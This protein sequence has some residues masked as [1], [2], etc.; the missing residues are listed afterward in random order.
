MKDKINQFIRR[1]TKTYQRRSIQF[2][3]SISFT[4][5]AIISMGFVGL[6]LYEKYTENSIELVNQKNKQ[7]I[8]QAGLNLDTYIRNMMNISDTMY[9]S[10]IKGKDLGYED[11][12]KEMALLYEANKNNLISIAC[13]DNMG[14]LI[15]ASP[16]GTM[17]EKVSVYN[18]DWFVQA[19]RKIENL[20]FSTPHV[21]DLFDD[22][23]FRYYW[24]VSL[25]RVVSLNYYGNTS[26]GILLVDMNFSDI[27]QLFSKVNAKGEGYVYLT[28]GEGEIIYHPKQK[29][30]YTNLMSE[31]NYMAAK[32][33]D[34][35]HIEKYEGEER[36]VIVKTVG[37]T[38]WKI[39]SVTPI[40]E[41]STNLNQFKF[42]TFSI[43]GVSIIVIIIG[44][45][46]IS[47]KVT[48]PIRKLEESVRELEN[49][50]LNSNIYTEGPHEIQHL[51]ST[52]TSMVNQMKNMMDD[53]VKEQEAKKKSE[54]DAL[55]SQINPHFL[56]NTLDS[57]VWMVES[58]R[59]PEAISMVTALASLFRISLSKGK[60]IISIKDE[61]QHADN[62]LKIQKVRYKD[63]FSVKT[64]IDP[65]IEEYSTIK[66]IV[67]PLLENAIYYG[68]ESMR[69]EGEITI[70]GYEEQGDIFIEVSDNGMGIPAE[71]Q[72]LLLTDNSRA[73]KRGSGIGLINVH[74]RIKLYYGEPY[75]LQI[76]SE[77][78]EGTTILI[79]LPKI[80]YKEE[81]NEK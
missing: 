44:N 59:Y 81:K 76:K 41:I 47:E 56:Y 55:Q 75:G 40:R 61:I 32:Y 69:D 18:Q 33:E 25:S 62:Y 74:Q 39:I 78:D 45:I 67:Q 15:A 11:M 66:L 35:S 53:I 22:S 48:N 3:V 34:G 9:Y 27:E 54:L 52:I 13:F 77:L 43:L 38:G 21:Q 31:N 19:N 5:I 4:A 1:I 20:H 65:A 73:R 36:A 58:E 2:T 51:G 42:F 28:D 8:D 68:V 24:V 12:N 80:K 10:V 37:Y 7:L 14:K 17:K 70:R 26:R 6:T 50:N 79:H 16:I 63:Q 29:M 57:I 23:N 49:G 64:E 71:E 46:L 60:N 30:I 72:E